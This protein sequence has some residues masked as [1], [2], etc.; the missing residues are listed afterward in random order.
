[1]KRTAL[2]TAAA[3]LLL[4]ACGDDPQVRSASV[5]STPRSAAPD[6]TATQTAAPSP[7]PSEASDEPPFAAD[8]TS[9]EQT[10]SG[11]PLSVTAIRVGTHDGYDRVVFELDG[12]QPGEPGWF[13]RYE[14]DPRQQGSGDPIDV[15]G[16]AVLALRITG[17]GYPM[18]TG[19]EEQPEPPS[20]PRGAKVVQ[21]ISRGSVFEGQHEVFIGTSGK[22]PFRV[23]RLD[24]PARV[25]VD[26]RHD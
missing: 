21:E 24:D 5:D 15:D 23:F 17:V 10:A 6:T 8:T 26:F 19:V 20:V 22:A 4:A 3:C 2:A 14:D 9:D 12:K 25:V 13:A 18:D 1:M 11:G 7:S 16:E